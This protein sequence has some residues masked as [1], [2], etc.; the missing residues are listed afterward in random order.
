MQ[1]LKEAVMHKWQHNTNMGQTRQENKSQ[2]YFLSKECAGGTNLKHFL[3][4]LH[5][6]NLAKTPH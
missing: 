4:P 6:F 1:L 2:K 3:G 5:F